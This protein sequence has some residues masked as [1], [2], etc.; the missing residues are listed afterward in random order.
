[1]KRFSA[2]GTGFDSSP[3]VRRVKPYGFTLIEL[4]VVIAIIAILA[5]ILLPTL[6]SARARGQA[7]SCLSNLKQIGHANHRYLMDNNEQGGY[8]MVMYLPELDT[9]LVPK[10]DFDWQNFRSDVWRCPANMVAKKEQ[11]PSGF[12][13]TFY[14]NIS[15]FGNVNMI[16]FKFNRIK[17]PAKKV[18][19]YDRRSSNG[20]P[21]YS[22]VAYSNHADTSKILPGVH[23]GKVN[24]LFLDG[25]ARAVGTDETN[26]ISSKATNL[27]EAWRP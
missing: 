7:T 21:L 10:R 18:F 25:H 11:A 23:N 27:V 1:M 22:D 14:K 4:L 17:S 15:Y 3:A 16:K 19:A 5:A 6:Q 9:Y 13:Y 20:R 2:I 8:R 24:F 26:I 12:Y